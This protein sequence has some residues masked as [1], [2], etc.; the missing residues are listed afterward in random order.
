MRKMLG[1]V[2]VVGVAC[3]IARVPPAASQVRLMDA[4]IGE[5]TA[6]FEEEGFAPFDSRRAGELGLGG[7][8]REEIE[9][10]A[11][12][13]YGIVGLCDVDCS[14]L[15]DDKSMADQVGVSK[16]EVSRETIEAGTRVLKELV[17]RD[18]SELDV[19]VVYLDGIV[20]GDYHVLAAVGVDADGRKHVLGLCGGASENTEVTA[21]LLEDLVARGLRADRRRLFVIDGAK[22]LRQAIGRVFGSS[23]LVQR[24][25]NHKVRN[26]LGH[27]PK[28][29]HE[30]ARSTLRAAWKLDADE[31]IRKLEQYASWLEREWPSAAGSLREGLSELF[32]VNRLGLPKPLRRCLT[33]TNIIDSSHA[34]VRQHT[35]RVSRWQSEEMAVRW[36]AVTFR[37]TEKHYRRITGYEHLWM[38]KAHLDEEDGV[39]AELQKAG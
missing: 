32:T 3:M 37:E 17:E 23:N 7:V 4:L 22:A 26:V 30:Q 6:V 31:G 16:S 12:T 33:T 14:D 29:Q 8:A 39:L 35:N 36:A 24:C 25:R 10:Q 27:L 9:L 5:T 28:E 38:L 19:L 2:V 20:F 15:D 13:T 34:G 11:G 21:G 1:A 18:L